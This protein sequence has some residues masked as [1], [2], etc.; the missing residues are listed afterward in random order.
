VVNRTLGCAPSATA[1]SSTRSTPFPPGSPRSWPATRPVAPTPRWSC[2]PAGLDLA[3]P[4]AVRHPHT[5]GHRILVR[6][7]AGAAF[8]QHLHVACLLHLGN[9]RCHPGESL[10]S[11]AK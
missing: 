3:P 6:I 8:D 9:G 1:S 7:Q 11:A 5:G 10:S 2:E 4:V